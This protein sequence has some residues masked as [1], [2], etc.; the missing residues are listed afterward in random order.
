MIARLV[1]SGNAAVQFARERIATFFNQNLGK[2]A[3]EADF[4]YK[5]DK[6]RQ[7]SMNIGKGRRKK[8]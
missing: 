5:N 3:K 4:A 2:E 6:L 8:L 1:R 7:I